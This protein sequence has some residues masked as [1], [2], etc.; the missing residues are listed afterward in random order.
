[1]IDII[2]EKVVVDL[3]IPIAVKEANLQVGWMWGKNIKLNRYSPVIPQ[4]FSIR[5]KFTSQENREVLLITTSIH[6]KPSQHNVIK[7]STK[8]LRTHQD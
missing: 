1:M 5:V 3:P 4:W 6:R 7:R 8:G 2:H